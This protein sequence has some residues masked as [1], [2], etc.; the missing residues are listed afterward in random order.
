[1]DGGRQRERL[2]HCGHQAVCDEEG[3]PT[4]APRDSEGLSRDRSSDQLRQR[5]AWSL[6]Q[7]LVMSHEGVGTHRK[8]ELYLTYY[9]ILVRHAFGSYKE[10][11]REVS[12]SPVMAK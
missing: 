9:D 6:S 11:L 8:T 1:M 10:L 4:R 2:D 3:G 12:Y 5:V 7:T